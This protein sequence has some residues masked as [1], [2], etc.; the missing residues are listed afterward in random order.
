M[1]SYEPLTLVIKTCPDEHDTDEYD[2]M[3]SEN[4][5]VWGGLNMYHFSHVTC[6]NILL[7]PA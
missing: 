2:G 1:I 3:K 7:F 6:D 5:L 4:F